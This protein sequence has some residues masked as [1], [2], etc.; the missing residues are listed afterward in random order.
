ML[1]KHTSAPDY[2]VLIVGAGI[3]GISAASYLAKSCPKKSFKILERRKRVGGTWDLFNYP[4]I[5][6][7]SEVSTFAFS[8]KPW[9]GDKTLAAGG[10]IRDY[11]EEAAREQGVYDAIQFE[12]RV[13]GASWDSSS[14]LWTVNYIDETTGK[15]ASV[16]ARFTIAAT[17]YYDYDQGYL[18]NFEGMDDFS[19]KIVH[20][21]HWPENFDYKGKKVVVI[22]SGATAVTLL[23]A[24]ADDTA[25]ITMLQR[26]P[27]YVAAVPSKNPIT[28]AL[29]GKIPD[30]AV[31]T[32]SRAQNITFQRMFFELSRKYP[33]TIR[34]LLLSEVKKRLGKDYDMSHFSPSYNPWDQRLCAVP[35][36]DM[37]KAIKAG[38]AS[39]VTDHIE[40]FTKTGIQLKSG[41][42]LDAD[43]IVTATGLKILL[44][45]HAEFLVDGKPF[46]L[47]KHLTYKG[48]M[49]EGL[50]NAAVI[51]GYTNSSW[52]LKSDIASNYIT[53][54]LNYMDKKGYTTVVAKDFD[55]SV[56][57]GT[58]FGK[59][60]SG[61]VMR[62]ADQLP[63]QGSK[64]P[65]LVTHNY[66]TDSI[67]LR[68]GKINDEYLHFG[69]PTKKKT[70][71]G[72][73][74]GKIKSA[75][76]S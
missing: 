28:K 49:V 11:I 72:K 45:G 32:L 14:Q 9:A 39:V 38:K 5:R 58:V 71:I 43:I 61:Y 51:F 59:M 52:T 18:P 17:G 24:M 10:E 50:P 25:H 19:G 62:A 57:D 69:K 73:G 33:K 76:L 48:V 1:K 34:K 68:L 67:M 42:H 7:D 40:K 75:V 21:Q 70:L 41:K 20:P 13:T 36:G 6:S 31:Y 27:T 30:Q 8:F 64:K 23:P 35:S 3:S 56:G 63:K 44:G 54:L 66:F 60:S 4:G 65:W 22:G 53:R 74:L 15:P 29:R 2:D 47:S 12:T 55:N 37:F 46:D 16:S 26:S